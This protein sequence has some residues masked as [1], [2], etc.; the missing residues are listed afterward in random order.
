MI[1]H[2]TARTPQIVANIIAMTLTMV[3]HGSDLKLDILEAVDTI[4]TNGKVYRWDEYVAN[5]VKN[6][7]EKF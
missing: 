1:S 6:I 7:C 3:G 5:M 4:A 2:I